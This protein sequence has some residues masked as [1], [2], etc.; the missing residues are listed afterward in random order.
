LN[1]PEINK[2]RAPHKTSFDL[3]TI[4]NDTDYTDMFSYTS[5][6]GS[7]ENT[8]LFLTAIQLLYECSYSRIKAPHS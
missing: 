8:N 2:Y 7:D 5:N 3:I 1:I 4:K 6:Y